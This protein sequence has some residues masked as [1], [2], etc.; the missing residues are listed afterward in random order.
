MTF[1]ATGKLLKGDLLLNN[2]WNSG[3]FKDATLKDLYFEE[4][5]LVQDDNK[6]ET[7]K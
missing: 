4:G 5:L 1:Q 7:R 3:L 6:P 2:N